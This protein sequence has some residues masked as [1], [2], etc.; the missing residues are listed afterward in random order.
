MF[1]LIRLH[2]PYIVCA[3][4]LW[5]QINRKTFL[6]IILK[7]TTLKKHHIQYRPQI[8]VHNIYIFLLCTFTHS[9]ACECVSVS[10]CHLSHQSSALLLPGPSTLSSGRWVGLLGKGRPAANPFSQLSCEVAESMLPKKPHVVA[11]GGAYKF[12]ACW[13][14]ASYS[15]SP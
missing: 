8:H 7:H 15:C 2:W 12:Q 13:P 9:L 10:V 6:V 5:G 11:Q 1:S 14:G 4:S 3:H